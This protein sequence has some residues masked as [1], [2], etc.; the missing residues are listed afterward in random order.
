MDRYNQ[1]N[2]SEIM[3]NAIQR[4]IENQRE[5]DI[6]KAVLIKDEIRKKASEDYDS[7]NIIRCFR[8]ERY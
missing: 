7:V 3:R 6:A 8:E 2:W 1:I 5:K 4:E